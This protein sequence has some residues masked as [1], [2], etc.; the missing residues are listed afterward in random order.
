[1]LEQRLKEVEEKLTRFPDSL[2]LTNDYFNLISRAGISA[3]SDRFKKSL[4]NLNISF[5]QGHNTISVVNEYINPDV[6]P[7]LYQID[8]LT[9]SIEGE[10]LEDLANSGFASSVQNL[11]LT[12]FEQEHLE[13]LSAFGSIK[14][15]GIRVGKL[16]KLSLPENLTQ[17]QVLKCQHNITLNLRLNLVLPDT[18]ISLKYLNCSH[19][20]LRELIIPETLQNLEEIYCQRNKIGRISF[21]SELLNLHKFNCSHND[22]TDLRIPRSKKLKKF[23]SYRNP[24]WVVRVP[25]E[26]EYERAPNQARII[27]Y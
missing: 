20:K 1:M 16:R 5:L 9:V 3:N 27:R 12:F 2:D 10:E 8:D 13:Y 14:R 23:T 11:D 18:W 6:R 19:N 22:I 24:L 25:K 26:M 7:F 17:L 15:L 4:S 21:P